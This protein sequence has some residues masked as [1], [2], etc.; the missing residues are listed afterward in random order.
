MRVRLTPAVVRAAKPGT[1]RV[2][3]WDT[4]VPGLGLLIHPSGRRSWVFQGIVSGG[5]RVTIRA[6]GLVEARKAAISLRVGLTTP[7]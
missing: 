5:R 2:F 3:L 4:E 6:A 7:E 1:S